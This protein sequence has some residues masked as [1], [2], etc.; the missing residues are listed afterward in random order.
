MQDTR[1]RRRS[2]ERPATL[3]SVS[4]ANLDEILQ[5][6]GIE[7]GPQPRRQGYVI[8]DRRRGRAKRRRS[9]SQDQGPR[10]PEAPSSSPEEASGRYDHR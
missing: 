3:S 8:R 9:E 4:Q 7:E 2:A 5:G 10:P 6:Y 1:D